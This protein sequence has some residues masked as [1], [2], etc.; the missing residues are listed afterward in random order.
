[1]AITKE[2]IAF[3]K[4]PVLI[5][6]DVLTF[7][8]SIKLII[9][10]IVFYIFLSIGYILLIALLSLIGLDLPELPAAKM[11]KIYRSVIIA[12]VIEELIFRLPLRNFYKNVF[13]LGGLFLYIVLKKL[14]P[15]PLAAI[16]G[17]VSMVLPYFPKLAGRLEIN[18]NNF[19]KQYYVGVFYFF[20]FS[21]GIAHITNL[22]NISS[23]T[24]LSLLV[25]LINPLAVGL[26]FA[27]VRIKYKNGILYAI[28]LHSLTNLLHYLPAFF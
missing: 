5:E 11:S 26:F 28:I 23:E 14:I 4:H 10:G 9:K 21:F 24:Y 8:Q 20:A 1:M 25:Y 2:F 19:V 22:L 27:F 13:V 16:F 7:L 12:P 17:L 15:V 3:L 6:P 18:I